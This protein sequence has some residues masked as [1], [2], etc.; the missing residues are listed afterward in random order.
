MKS[1]NNFRVA[2]VVPL[3]TNIISEPDKISLDLLQKNLSE[4]S[5]NVI[6]P[7][8]F[9]KYHP[10]FIY[11]ELDSKY[12]LN[13]QTYSR[14]LLSKNFYSMFEEYDYLLIYQTDCLVFSKDLLHWCKLGYDYIGAPLFK[15]INKPSMG[16][17]RVGNGG[18]SLRKVSS[19]LKVLNSRH[20]IKWSSIFRMDLP[21]R[22]FWDYYKKINVIKE[23][24]KGID[25]YVKNYSLNEDLFWSDRAKLF[26]PELK[27]APVE[28]GLKFAFEA[29]PRYCFEKNMNN[30]PFG[31][32]AWEKWD[33]DFWKNWIGN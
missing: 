9:K 31:A 23:T 1:E 16:F 11:H 32:H 24:K 13:T 22:P 12:F 6:C 15:N 29:H 14:L 20:M 5:I 17:S 26:Y 25:W 7:P 27:I 33:S 4:F 3:Y 28:I 19:F 18:F 2:V 10:S 21:D 8:R 30:L